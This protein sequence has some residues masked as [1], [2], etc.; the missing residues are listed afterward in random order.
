MWCDIGRI[1]YER[2]CQFFQAPGGP[3]MNIHW[4]RA[5]LTGAPLP[6]PS[7]FMSL[8]WEKAPWEQTGVGEIWGKR[9]KWIPGRT[10]PTARGTHWAGDP[11]DFQFGFDYDPLGPTYQRDPFGL[12]VSCSGQNPTLVCGEAGAKISAEGVSP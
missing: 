9:P 10:P 6:F 11:K 1:G 4:Y 12:L 3:V 5:P 2:P 7:R 8:N